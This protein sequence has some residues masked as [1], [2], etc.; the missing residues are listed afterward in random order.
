MNILRKLRTL[1]RREKFDAE[2]ADEM[3][4]HVDMQTERNIAAGMEADEARYAALRQ[5]GNVSSLQERARDVRHWR[6]LDDLGRDVRLGARLL[7]KTPGFTLV[8]VFSLALGIGANTAMFSLV[9]AVLLRSLPV[10]RPDEL[11][12]FRWTFQEHGPQVPVSGSWERDPAT[13]KMTCTSFSL[14]MLEELRK[15]EKAF[16]GVFGFA[17][18]Q[19]PKSIVQIDGQAETCGG[20]QLVSGNYS[21]VLG[22]QMP[23]GRNL[24]AA[25][26][27][28]AAPPVA[29]ISYRYWQAR[30]AG[31]P[32]VIGKTIIVNNVLVTIVGVTP[33]GFHGTLDVGETPDLSLPLAHAATLT[34]GPLDFNEP[35]FWWVC[36]MG[37]RQPGV[38]LT[39]AEASAAGIFQQ[40]ARESMDAASASHQ[41]AANASAEIPTLALAPGGQGLMDARHSYT[42]QLLILTVLV[43]M[44]LLI[45][46]ANVANL[47]LARA[48][49]RR[50]E[51]AMRLALGASRSRLVR[52]LLTESGLLALLGT[53]LG[54][55]FAYWGK[56]LLL[57]IQPFPGRNFSPDLH[58]N[59]TV[60]AMACAAA[61]VTGIL[62]GLA[63]ALSATRLDL[64][65]EFQGGTRTP[66]ANSRSWLARGLLV[67]QVAIS[68]I[69]VI[70]TGLFARTLGNV[71]D[72]DPGFNRERLLLFDLNFGSAG[73]TEATA[74]ALLDRVATQIRAVP[75]VRSASFATM[76]LLSR[77]GWN[78]NITIPGQEV[79]TDRPE[80]AMVNTVD[81]EYFATLDL[82]F[83]LGRGFTARDERG[84]PPVAVVNQAMAREFFG[85]EN[86][87]GRRF[88][89][90]HGPGEST[91]VE[92]VGVVRD[93]MYADVRY[94]KPGTIYLPFAQVAMNEATFVVRAAID[95]E[96]LTESVRATVQRIEP[97]LPVADARSLDTQVERLF[98]NEQLFAHLSGA[99]GGLALLLVSV[100]LYGLMT[101]TVARRTSE[102]GVRMALGALP[103]RVLWM[104][105]RQ[106]VGL[107]LCGTILGL[108]GAGFATRL[109]TSMLYG[110]SPLDPA[111]YVS[112][113]LLLLFAAVVAA[114]IPARRAALIDP[115]EALRAE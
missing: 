5:F 111:T 59:A 112:A 69:L 3:R 108:V 99:F 104:V 7:L 60:L 103:R 84:A 41:T 98:A 91:E 51:I 67:I 14:R 40:L 53:A 81:P 114:W 24:S 10:E 22:L 4:A 30:F 17:L 44:V 79:K 72:V 58:L 63:P 71:R 42:R 93:A 45:A 102:I 57:A 115:V 55:G 1:F 77:A 70:G 25:D 97:R 76:P 110:L 37:R 89:W 35:Y 34:K 13:G 64:N 39:Q 20:L 38:T 74:P 47:L 52:Q 8:A 29:M 80:T 68:I 95:P 85:D 92:I 21:S 9:D 82:P 100:G 36:I 2:M 15:D 109:V 18:I 96:A 19:H 23:V 113:A 75:G 31:D 11:T 105:L 56:D 54:I 73:Y 88:R 26:D 78:T 6:S 32:A 62:F 86:P 28:P 101:Y 48:A 106:S 87:V 50:R 12:L 43:G 46:C 16:A 65:T 33:R 107:V 90:R 61:V 94:G 49:A 66:G 83:V 27:D